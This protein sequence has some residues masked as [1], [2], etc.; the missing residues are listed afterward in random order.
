M[1]AAQILSRLLQRNNI[2]KATQK[3]WLPQANRNFDIFLYDT[4]IHQF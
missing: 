4:L 3:L 1:A 2:I